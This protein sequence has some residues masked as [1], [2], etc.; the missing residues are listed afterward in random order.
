[1]SVVRSS[2]TNWNFVN[3]VK[4]HIFFQL[5]IFNESKWTRQSVQVLRLELFKLN[6]LQKHRAI[7]ALMRVGRWGRGL[8]AL[9]WRWEED[10]ERQKSVDTLSLSLPDK[11]AA[12]FNTNSLLRHNDAHIASHRN[13]DKMLYGALMC[14]CFS[15][16]LPGLEWKSFLI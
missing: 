5:I 7:R 1:M 14:F 8:L 12:L 2:C 11:K 10:R 3:I 9:G 16:Q 13:L 4:Y 6:T 15:H